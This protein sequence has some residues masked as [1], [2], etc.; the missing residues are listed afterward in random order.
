MKV[1]YKFKKKRDMKVRKNKREK[2]K[3]RG[4]ARSQRKES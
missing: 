2:G 3:L 4:G 1:F